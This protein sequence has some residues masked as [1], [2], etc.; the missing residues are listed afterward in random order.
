MQRKKYLYSDLLGKD[1]RK[2]ELFSKE[3]SLEESQLIKLSGEEVGLGC[4]GAIKPFSP[5]V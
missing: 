3:W 5:F 4:S 1:G 2:E